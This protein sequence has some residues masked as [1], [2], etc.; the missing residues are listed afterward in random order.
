MW[1][2]LLRHHAT[3]NGVAIAIVSED[4]KPTRLRSAQPH[5]CVQ[6]GLDALSRVGTNPE[7]RAGMLSN[8]SLVLLAWFSSLTP[9]AGDL[10]E[11]IQRSAVTEVF[12]R[13]STEP[14]ALTTVQLEL[15]PDR[16]SAE[17]LAAAV[18]RKLGDELEVFVEIVNGEAELPPSFR[19]AVG[20][21]DE[22]EQAE[23]AQVT[24]AGLGIDGFVRQLDVIIGC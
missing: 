20:P 10:L 1:H 15:L 3:L 17:V 2:W 11:L 23:R 24:L 7:I 19:V 9:V 4:C 13:P 21:F 8:I 12:E 22:I 16:Y 14:G 18:Q 6:A 5:L